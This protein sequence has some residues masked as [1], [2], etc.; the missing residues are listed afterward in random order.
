ML[1]SNNTRVIGGIPDEITGILKVLWCNIS[2]ARK[3]RRL[4]VARLAGLVFVSS[5]T[6]GKLERGDPSV[7][8]GIFAVALY[9]LRLSDDLKNVGSPEHDKEGLFAEMKRFPYKLEC[10]KRFLMISNIE[11][12]ISMEAIL[13]LL[14]KCV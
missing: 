4:S 2:I 9:V 12:L 7:S 14:T 6:I 13:K 11:K 3:R 8:L 5:P 10:E 1:K